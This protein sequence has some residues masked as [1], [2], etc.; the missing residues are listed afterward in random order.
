MSAEYIPILSQLT[1]RGRLT[2]AKLIVEGNQVGPLCL[3]GVC[4][5]RAPRRAGV[6]LKGEICSA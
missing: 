5:R 1:G 3:S 4:G 2:A 6:Q